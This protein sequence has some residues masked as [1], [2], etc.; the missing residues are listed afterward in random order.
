[1]ASTSGLQY[2]TKGHQGRNSRQEPKERK[3]WRNAAYLL[4][5]RFIAISFRIEPKPTYLQ[6]ALLTVAWTCLHQLIRK[7]TSHR[8]PM[9]QSGLSKS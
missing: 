8:Q 9:S 4:T 1:M 2:I 3:Q 7:T 5:F 6:M